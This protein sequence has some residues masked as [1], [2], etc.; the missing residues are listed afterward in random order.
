MKDRWGLGD[1]KGLVVV[2]R[3][4]VEPT[5]DYAE[6]NRKSWNAKQC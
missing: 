4:G 2:G 5:S 1:P 6:Y 3:V